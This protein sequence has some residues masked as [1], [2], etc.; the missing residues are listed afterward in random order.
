MMKYCAVLLA[1]WEGYCRPLLH[2][3]LQH[4][5]QGG[6]GW[7]PPIAQPSFFAAPAAVSSCFPEPPA[8]APSSSGE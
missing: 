6:G 3:L 4:H 5:C 1:L 8:S 2:A 7:A